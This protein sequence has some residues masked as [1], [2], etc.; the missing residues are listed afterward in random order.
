M[1]DTYLM[2]VGLKQL[3]CD[4]S[5][6]CEVRQAAGDKPV[7]SAVLD[8]YKLHQGDHNSVLHQLHLRVHAY[9]RARS[10]PV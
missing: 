8:S 5:A 7:R 6:C 10:D 3:P 2:T 1:T 4:V 9:M